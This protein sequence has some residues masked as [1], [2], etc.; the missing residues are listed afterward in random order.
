MNQTCGAEE[1]NPVYL[2][3]QADFLHH[4]VDPGS[5]VLQHLKMC[6]MQDNL[7]DGFDI[8]L[9]V[10]QKDFLKCRDIEKSEKRDRDQQH[11][12]GPEGELADQTLTK[13]S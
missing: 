2:F 5:I 7:T 4:L 3:M 1:P 9:G 8:I 10:L 6:C 11:D 13:G 12:T